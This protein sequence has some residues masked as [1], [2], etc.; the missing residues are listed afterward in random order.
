MGAGGIDG[1]VGQARAGVHRRRRERLEP[2]VAVDGV[3][4]DGSVA[5]VG[6]VGPF[7]GDV[8]RDRCG[9]RAGRALA[10][11]AQPPAGG[12]E[13]EAADAVVALVGD[14]HE[15]HHRRAAH[16]HT[17]HARAA[18]DRAFA[19]G[20]GA[21]LRRARRLREDRD[22]V[23]RAVGERRGER[24]GA[25]GGDG[26]VVAGVVLQDEPRTGQAGDGA[27]DRRAGAA[28]AAEVAAAGH[29]HRL[30]VAVAA[31]GDRGERQQPPCGEQ[32]LTSR[33]IV[34]LVNLAAAVN[35]AG[36]YGYLSG[37]SVTRA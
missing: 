22:V 23:A 11:V 12:V 36:A 29:V 35:C 34:R 6:D 28:V 24:E 21:D 32:E 27:A 25:A 5:G 15:A 16:R 19:I 20:D 33:H 3:L 1:D 2:P 9:L 7:P 13:R 4:R 30:A 18:G 8:G 10:G 17:R 31:A 26:E 37:W 14:E